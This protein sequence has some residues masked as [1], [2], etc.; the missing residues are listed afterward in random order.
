MESWACVAMSTFCLPPPRACKL[1]AGGRSQRLKLN[2]SFTRAV[3]TLGAEEPAL[4]SAAL[5]ELD[6]S[7]ALPIA[8]RATTLT[9]VARSELLPLRSRVR[10]SC[11]RGEY[12]TVF[13]AHA[14]AS[15]RL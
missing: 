10:D 4:Y 12:C 7:W 2:E 5:H 13:C 8:A 3:A 1:G 11:V 14:N 15:Q 6:Q 9:A